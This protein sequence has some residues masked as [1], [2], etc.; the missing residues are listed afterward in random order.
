MNDLFIKAFAAL[1]CTV[2]FLESFFYKVL[3]RIK[4]IFAAI[5][6]SK[7]KTDVKRPRLSTII[8]LSEYKRLSRAAIIIIPHI[9]Y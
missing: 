4:N 5:V 6:T 9:G 8:Q 7:Y 3:S 1:V 2:T